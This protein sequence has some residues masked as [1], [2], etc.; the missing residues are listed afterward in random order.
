MQLSHTGGSN[1]DD[2]PDHLLQ[3]WHRVIHQPQSQ[4]GEGQHHSPAHEQVR[5]QLHEQ[6]SR[7]SASVPCCYVGWCH[8]SA[9]VSRVGVRREGQPG[10]EPCGLLLLFLLSETGYEAGCVG[11]WGFR[12][13]TPPVLLQSERSPSSQGRGQLLSVGSSW[14][15]EPR[16]VLMKQEN[17]FFLFQMTY[18][19]EE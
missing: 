6:Q 18:E 9:A 4:H 15:L 11:V 2:A 7:A 10:P 8:L 13:P 12:T 19:S 3:P 17:L 14:G 1:V 16:C 5:E